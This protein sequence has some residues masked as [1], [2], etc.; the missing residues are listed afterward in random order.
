VW[1]GDVKLTDNRT[2]RA[3]MER[4]QP[5]LDA[6]NALALTLAEEMDVAPDPAHWPELAEALVF[7]PLLPPRYRLSGAGAM[8]GAAELFKEQLAASPRAPVQAA[9]LQALRTFG[10]PDLA[11]A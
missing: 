2:M 10:L 3:T 11:L 5:P 8:S 1:A 9:D 6:H 7:G 4:G